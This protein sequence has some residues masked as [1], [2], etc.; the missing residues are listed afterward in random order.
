MCKPLLIAKQNQFCLK[1]N[2]LKHIMS[3]SMITDKSHNVP[4]RPKSWRYLG[5]PLE[6]Q[7][8]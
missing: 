5:A 3:D 7:R 2:T 8:P 1:I 6:G 4:N